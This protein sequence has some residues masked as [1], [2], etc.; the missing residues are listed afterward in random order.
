MNKQL[1]LTRKMFNLPVLNEGNRYPHISDLPDGAIAVGD[2][3]RLFQLDGYRLTH[4]EPPWQLLHSTEETPTYKLRFIFI[5]KRGG[6]DE[7]WVKG[8]FLYDTPEQLDEWE[9]G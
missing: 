6:G 1:K 8:G 9:R 3:L 4:I 2:A 7:E 5:L